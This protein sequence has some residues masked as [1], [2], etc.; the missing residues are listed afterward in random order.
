MRFEFEGDTFAIDFKREYKTIRNATTIRKGVEVLVPVKSKF[1][2]T[3][4]NLLKLDPTKRGLVGSSIYATATV[5]AWHREPVFSTETG[6]LRA[7]RNLVRTLPKSMRP[8]VFSAYFSR[9]KKV[10]PKVPPSSP[11]SVLTA[12]LPI[13]AGEV[14]T[15]PQPELTSVN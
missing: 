4:A 9:V 15:I 10:E 8:K 3:T 6:R 2:Y 13:L 11:A 1:P 7:L 14:R 5:G 12:N